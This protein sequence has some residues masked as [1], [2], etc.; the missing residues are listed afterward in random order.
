M[1]LSPEFARLRES[2]DV[3]LVTSGGL[4]ATRGRAT[5]RAP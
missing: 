3:T 1:L 2:G 5:M 4:I